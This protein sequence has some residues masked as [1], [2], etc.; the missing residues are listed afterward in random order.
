[1]RGIV[2]HVATLMSTDDSTSN[3]TS[4]SM[5]RNHSAGDDVPGP[6]ASGTASTPASW[7]AKINSRFAEYDRALASSPQA[8]RAAT[9][10]GGAAADAVIGGP[11]T[12]MR[13]VAVFTISFTVTL[14]HVGPEIRAWEIV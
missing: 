3:V 2:T 9:T 7:V 4:S 13:A 6:F 10:F 12:D 14:K 8:D 5:A 1:M 11:G